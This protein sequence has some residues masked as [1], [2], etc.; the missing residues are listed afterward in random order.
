VLDFWLIGAYTELDM[1]GNLFNGRKLM[2]QAIRNNSG[3]PSFYIEYLKF[4][5]KFY[6]K[7]KTRA[8]ILKGDD[9]KIDFIDDEEEKM[10]NVLDHEPIHLDESSRFVEIA[11]DNILETFEH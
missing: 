5:I 1:R 11:F 6:E 8:L 4:E 2:L 3:S 7:L 9:K 10:D